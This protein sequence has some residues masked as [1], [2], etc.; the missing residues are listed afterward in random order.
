[1]CIVQ[2]RGPLSDDMN[3]EYHIRS[4]FGRRVVYIRAQM[5]DERANR[6]ARVTTRRYSR[7]PA[8]C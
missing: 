8:S 5:V 7:H 4:N 6:I 1:M 2:A 3:M